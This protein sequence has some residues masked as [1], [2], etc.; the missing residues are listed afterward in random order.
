MKHNKPFHTSPLPS[1]E[2]LD[3][4]EAFVSDTQMR[5]ALQEECLQFMPDFLYMSKKLTSGKGTLQVMR[6]CESRWQLR[7]MDGN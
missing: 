4:V 6:V 1:D 5:Q 2:R 7:G 3:V